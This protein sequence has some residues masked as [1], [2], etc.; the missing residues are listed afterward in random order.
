[1]MKSGWNAMF[2][3]VLNLIFPPKCIFCGEILS[4]S[5]KINICG[6]CFNKIPFMKENYLRRSN[7]PHAGESC[8]AIV[9][10]CEYS[11][12]IKEAIRRYKFSNKSSYY[13]V[14]GKLLSDKVKKM[15]N[16]WKFDIIISVPLH[17]DRE[18]FRG[19]NQSYLISKILSKG[20]GIEES[21]YLLKR[22]V[23]TDTQSLLSRN[24]RIFNVRGA[25][26]VADP[27]KVKGKT[28]L[29]VDDILTTGSTI[30]ECSRVLKENGASCVVAAV[31]ASGRK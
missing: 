2:N 24:E 23:R 30:N 22:M 18:S 29:L 21:S 12:I 10:V 14:F 9:C 13:R 25:F 28:I 3:Y 20:L 7:E 1:M 4:A 26:K 19:Y 17:K 31:I 8:D 16:F 6:S 15:T 5:V 11:G 27:G